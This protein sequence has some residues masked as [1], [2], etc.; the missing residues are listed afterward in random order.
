[1]AASSAA[2]LPFSQSEDLSTLALQLEITR[3]ALFHLDLA[4]EMRI[5]SIEEREIY[6][7]ILSLLPG[8]EEVMGMLNV[9]NP[10]PISKVPL[11]HAPQ[12]ALDEILSPLVQLE[13]AN[14]DL[15]RLDLASKMRILSTDELDVANYSCLL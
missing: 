10:S 6:E 14:E 2:L 8:L 12:L 1:L 5:L 11:G 3:E 9:A 15:L 7:Y 13:I 4:S